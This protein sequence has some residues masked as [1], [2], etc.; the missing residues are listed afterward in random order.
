M[1]PLTQLKDIHLPEQIHAYPISY[2]WWVL[3]FIVFALLIWCIKK[4]ISLRKLNK[5]KKQAL[6]YIT[7]E[8]LSNDQ[9]ISILK[10]AALQY[11][12]RVSVANLYGNSLNEFL[13]RCLPEKLQ[14]DFNKQMQEALSKQY[15][16][17]QTGIDINSLKATASL[18]LNKAL[19]PSIK[20]LNSLANGSTNTQDEKIVANDKLSEGK[21]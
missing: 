11:F 6:H 19:P 16:L 9:L 17:S 7:D 21:A 18:W 10:W 20:T 5:A 1:D 4:I 12:P 8:H 3:L 14:Q 15:Q 2:G 13:T